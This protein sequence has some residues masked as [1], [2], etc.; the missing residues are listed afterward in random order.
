M[1]A[2]EDGTVFESTP[3]RISTNTATGTIGSFIDLNVLYE[4][5]PIVE[6]RGDQ[7]GI[8]FMEFGKN[9]TEIL[10]KGVSPNRRKGRARLSGP[11]RFDNQAT[12]VLKIY[13][14]EFIY[15]NM[16]VFN[17]GKVQMTGIK[18]ISDGILAIEVLINVVKTLHAAMELENPAILHDDSDGEKHKTIVEDPSILAAGNYKIHLINSDF[19]VNFEIKREALHRILVENCGNKC[20]YEPCIYPGVK[21][22]YY[23]SEGHNHSGNC[24]CENSICTGKKKGMF[25]KKI[26]IAIFQS[27]C[28]II[29]G[30]NSVDQINDCYKYICDVLKTHMNVV[31]KKKF[32]ASVSNVDTNVDQKS[33]N[34]ITATTVNVVASI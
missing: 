19:R 27:G 16:K 32:S 15:V 2:I 8:V 31:K 3:Y 30:A 22:Q 12:T 5:A 1:Q 17:N 23:Y 29:T 10:C 28:I 18:K 33:V 9:K 26:T 14:N 25:C 24:P 21:L 20:S 7:A 34:S 4:Y 6:V 13:A 11:K